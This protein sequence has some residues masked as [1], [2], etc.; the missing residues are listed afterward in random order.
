MEQRENSRRGK[1]LTREDRMVI[2][3]MSRDKNSPAV[4]MLFIARDTG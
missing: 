3:T 2:E 1:H 4:F